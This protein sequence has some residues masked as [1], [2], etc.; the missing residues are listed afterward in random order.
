MSEQKMRFGILGAG[1]IVVNSIV[2]ALNRVEGWELAAVASRD[3]ERAADLGPTRAYT[4]YQELT[5]DPEIDVIYVATHNGLHAEQTIAAL[6][7]GKHVL[8]EKPLGCSVAECESIVAAAQASGKHMLEAFMYQYHPQIELA[9]KWLEQGRIGEL[10]T[11]E[12][13]FSFAH[14]YPNDVRLKR[15]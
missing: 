5:D 9:R 4:S 7:A 14:D 8:C 11:V 3:L 12:A 15:E 10:K 1:R 6:Q 13:S 2:P